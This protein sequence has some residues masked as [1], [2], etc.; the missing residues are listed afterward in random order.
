MYLK[1]ELLKA[2][3]DVP[4]VENKIINIHDENETCFVFAKNT[5][6]YLASD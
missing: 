4:L 1:L 6:D 2:L 3:E 5:G